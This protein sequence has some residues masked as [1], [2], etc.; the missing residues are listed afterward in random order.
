MAQSKKKNI[1][2]KKKKNQTSTNTKKKSTTKKTTTTVK[3]VSTSNKVKKQEA[4]KNTLEKKAE[5]TKPKSSTK[6]NKV[7]NIKEKSKI[8]I[9]PKEKLNVEKKLDLE[10]KKV[11]EVKKQNHKEELPRIKDNS[12]LLIDE[13]ITSEDLPKINTN[14]NGKKKDL[15]LIFDEK[16]ADINKNNVKKNSNAK[17]I[18]RSKTNKL[19]KSYKKFARKVKVYGLGS[20]IPIHSLV[21]IGCMILVIL[22]IV[23]GLNS[24]S[25]DINSMD[26]VSISQDIDQLKTVRFD[27][28]KVNDIVKN[29]NA[30]KLN[31]KKEV[32]LKE[33]YEYD[34]ET[35]G[36]KKEWILECVLKYNSKSKELFFVLKDKD[37]HHNELKSAIEKYLKEEKVNN[38]MYEEYDGYMFFINSSNN[39][40]VL[41]KIKQI[42]IK[43]FDILK[44]LNKKE[45]HEKYKIDNSLYTDYVVK[46]SM[47]VKS[48]TTEY[49]IFK[50]K[51]NS[52]LN[53]IKEKL[54][55]YFKN[56][57]EKWQDEDEVNYYLVKN[58]YVEEYNNYLIVVISYDNDL[59]LNLIKK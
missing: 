41:S 4:V 33:Y 21:V 39:Q 27:I 8:N 23:I 2:K 25:K 22:G 32:D 11:G 14:A 9:N 12:N 6:I 48:D 40:A 45:I 38:Y 24:F 51:N 49:M 59:V 37:D 10:E 15:L 34:Y 30:Y 53:K 54:E 20:I 50:T 28:N 17:K 58:R 29:S 36:I 57:E 35:L 19:I 13:Q 3:K 55:E 31:Q 5:N 52:N 42:Q 26:L 16:K 43:V 1:A 56:I 44:E 7:T 46:T 18:A 47:I